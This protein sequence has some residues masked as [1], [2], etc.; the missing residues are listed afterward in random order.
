[1]SATCNVCFRHCEIEEGGLG[2][3]RARKCENGNITAANY[4]KVTSIAFDPMSKMPFSSFHAEDMILSVGSYGC[5]LAC[6]FCKSNEISTSGPGM[7]PTKTFT[8]ESLAS[9]ALDYRDHGNIGLAFTYNEPLIGWEFVRDAAKRI[10]E[11]GMVS[12]LITNGA[13]SLE[14]LEELL[15]YI[16]AMNIDLKA[17]HEEYYSSYVSGDI[18][19]TMDFIERAA[20][21]CHVELTTLIVPGENDSEAEMECEAKWIAQLNGGKGRKIPLHIKRFYPRYKAA[22]KKATDLERL[23]RLASVAGKYLDNVTVFTENA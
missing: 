20:K 11:H 21:D 8:P 19:M 22:N 5:N 17:F 2:F 4:G 12:V 3:C 7:V 10:H 15:P 13:A 1:M 6:P 14:V 9:T 18:F 16:D 23:E